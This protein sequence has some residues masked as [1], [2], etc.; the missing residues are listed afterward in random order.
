[1]R[2]FSTHFSQRLWETNKLGGAGWLH[3]TLLRFCLCLELKADG[4]MTKTG[5]VTVHLAE[6]K[7]YQCALC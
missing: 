3:S 5:H 7:Q 2:L 6:D 1:M 4:V